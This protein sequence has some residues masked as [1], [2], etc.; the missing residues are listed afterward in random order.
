MG[1]RAGVGEASRAAAG[2]ATAGEI[3]TTTRFG[4]KRKNSAGEGGGEKSR[5]Q[6]GRKDKASEISRD[7][8]TLA[9][10]HPDHVT[11]AVLLSKL[12]LRPRKGE[13]V[14]SNGQEVACLR[15]ARGRRQVRLTSIPP[16]SGSGGWRSLVGVPRGLMRKICKWVGRDGAFLVSHGE[17]ETGRSETE[18]A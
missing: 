11:P 9:K 18:A 12:R 16:R 13:W 5:A 2:T 14:W 4:R 15:C 7:V 6:A 8:Q 3:S 17:T 1:Q 10:W